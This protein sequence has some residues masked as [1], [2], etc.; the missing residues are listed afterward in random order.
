MGKGVTSIDLAG[1]ST[2]ASVL[3]HWKHPVWMTS[4]ILKVDEG[5]IFQ[6][7]RG[8]STSKN[9]KLIF[10]VNIPSLNFT[11]MI[12]LSVTTRQPL[13]HQILW[14]AKETDNSGT[15]QRHLRDISLLLKLKKVGKNKHLLLTQCLMSNDAQCI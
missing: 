3:I 13:I 1:Y 10:S 14:I 7:N 9:C 5:Q 2:A 15:F 11:T 6:K 4:T 12:N 8:K